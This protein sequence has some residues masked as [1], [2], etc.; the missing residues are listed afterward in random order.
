MLTSF[1]GLVLSGDVES[2]GKQHVVDGGREVKGGGFVEF[3]S[4]I[5]HA[6]ALVPHED[7]VQF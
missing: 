4:R 1:G 2:V 7:W 3:M 5:V 6:G